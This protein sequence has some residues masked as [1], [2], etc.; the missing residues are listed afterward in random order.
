MEENIKLMQN[1]LSL[2]LQQISNSKEF[3]ELQAK[4]LGKS[5]EITGLMKELGKV[6]KE[7][8]PALGKLINSFKVWAENEFSY[9]LKKIGKK[10]L[11]EKYKSEKIDISMPSK[12]QKV[13]SL[14]PITLIKKEMIEIFEGLGFSMFEGPE[15]E[16]DYYNFTAL[17]VP[18]DHPA[19]DMQDTFFINAEMLLRTQTSPGQIRVMEQRK[20]PI[21]VM[22]PGKVFRSDDDATH[23]PMFHQMEGLVV[24]KGLTV[25]DL[26]GVLDN[27]AKALFD[28]NTKTRLRPSFFPFTEPSVEVDVQCFNCSGAGCKLCKNT[29][30]IEVLGG[31]MVHPNVLK[32][33]GIDP[34][35]YTGLALGVG[36]DRI[37]MLKYGIPNIKL[38]FEN[39]IR[40]LKQF[41]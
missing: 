35:I 12:S 20:P 21:K 30:W 1:Q 10:E 14:H 28:K 26:Y 17:N 6:S 37:A 8:R 7:E 34:E 24:D 41:K 31:G 36:M 33:G 27:L 39:D 29:G 23:S 5:G 11:E 16:S 4:Y 40:L 13:G 2:Q 38:L 18:K 25:C 32:N 9:E 3:F 15:I 19:R 22:V